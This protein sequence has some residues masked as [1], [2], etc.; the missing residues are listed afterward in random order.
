MAVNETALLQA[1]M[2]VGLFTLEELE[3][4]KRGSKRERVKLIEIVTREKRFPESALYQALSETRSMV[5]LNPWEL[6]P[7]RE[8]MDLLPPKLFRQRLFMP[9]QKK[10]DGY[11]VV[12]LADPDDRMSLE[13]VERVTGSI[14]KAGLSFP[15]AIKS[16]M[17]G[18]NGQ[19]QD[20]ESDP[21]VLLDEIMRE[22][23]LRRGSDIHFEPMEDLM[24]IRIRVDGKMQ[25]FHRKYTKV[26]EMPILNR[27]KVLAGLDIA[28]Q[29]MA[30]DGA[31]AYSIDGWKINPIDIRVATIP[32]KYGERCTMRILGDDTGL[33][34]L[35]QLGM[36][37]GMLEKFRYAITKPHGMI[38]VTGPTG[39]G[40]STTLYAALRELDM[41]RMNI[42]TAE[43]PVEQP[44]EGISQVQVTGKVSFAQALRS[45]LRHD[46]DVILVGEIRDI[47]TVEISLRAA[48]TG[49]LVLSTLHTNNAVGAVTRLVDVGAERFLIGSTLLAV[50]AQ[51]LARKLCNRC[52]TARK[53]DEN[54]L[55][56]LGLG[57][58]ADADIYESVGCAFC[59]G[60]GSSGRVGIFEAL[61]IDDALRIA[62]TEGAGEEEITRKAKTHTTLW[63]DACKKVVDGI[64]S[65]DDVRHLRTGE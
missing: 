25:E 37:K 26:E 65:F 24:R 62:I 54:E 18:I 53:A 30:Q 58:D 38:L 48:M 22:V 60:T 64:V 41:D 52:K 29:R 7:D 45:F 63:Q 15:A 44:V 8:V 31:M 57:S 19:L 39:S 36:G 17:A 21:V 47:E 12:A 43:D 2:D 61:W 51:R 32:T 27:I 40:K 56:L 13:R 5:F 6:I 1:G 49:H 20:K 9:V 55:L 14:F 33:L 35:K 46:P 11:P 28:E 59:N 50:M 3:V 23:Y 4:F 16:A 34:S 10:I 42:L